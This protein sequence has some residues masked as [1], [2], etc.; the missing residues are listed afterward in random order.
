MVEERLSDLRAYSAT[1]VEGF[2]RLRMKLGAFF[3]SLLV[4]H[5]DFEAEVLDHAPDFG[6]RLAWCC[7][8][9]VHEDGIGWIEGEGLKT[10]QIVFS[11]A[12]D[13]DFGTRVKKAEEAEHFQAALWSQLIAVF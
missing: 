12:G 8:V 5:F 6:G 3:S 1:Y 13:A 11:P 7:E 4:G 2:E 9:A 10:P